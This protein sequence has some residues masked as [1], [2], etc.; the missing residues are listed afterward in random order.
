M[1]LERS[2]L[3]PRY[4]TYMTRKQKKRLSNRRQRNENK[5]QIEKGIQE[6][7]DSETL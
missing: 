1:F 5:S 6:A 2:Q 4:K 7:E 3:K